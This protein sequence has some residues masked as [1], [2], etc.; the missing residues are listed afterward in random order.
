MNCCRKPQNK[1]CGIGYKMIPA[2]LGDDT[3]EFKPENGAYH[4]M[5]IKYEENGALYFYANDGVYV[6]L[7]ADRFLSEI[8]KWEKEAKADVD[9]QIDERFDELNVQQ[10]VNNKLEEMAA[11]GTLG[12]IIDQYLQTNVAWIFD[13]VADMKA[14]TNLVA[15]SYAQTL[16]FYS[17]NDGGGATYFITDDGTAN[18]MDIIAVGDLYANLVHIPNYYNMKTVGCKANNN[19]FDNSTIINAMMGARRTLFFPYGE[20]YISKPIVI[21]ENHVT[22]RGENQRTR[23]IK[24]TNDGFNLTIETSKGTTYNFNSID[25]NFYIGKATSS[26]GTVSLVKIEDLGIVCYDST[27]TGSSYGMFILGC[28][29][30]KT[31]NVQLIDYNRGIF[32]DDSFALNLNSIEA[33]TFGENRNAVEVKD[34]TAVYI[35]DSYL[36]GRYQSIISDNSRVYCHNVACESH[37]YVFSTVNAGYLTLVNCRSE[38]YASIV[39]A[40]GASQIN[41]T[42]CDLEG[43]GSSFTQFMRVRNNS[44]VSVRNSLIRYRVYEGETA[45]ETITGF[46]LENGSIVTCECYYNIHEGVTVN[47]SLQSSCDLWIIDLNNEGKHATLSPGTGVTLTDKKVYIK[48]GYLNVYLTGNTS[49]AMTQGSST[50]LCTISDVPIPTV[51]HRCLAGTA[52]SNLYTTYRPAYCGIN[53]SG[54]ITLTPSEENQ[55]YFVINTKYRIG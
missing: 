4:N 24:N 3:G 29:Y 19:T 53:T 47:N 41:I 45:P 20:Y 15:G 30:F 5:L 13:T 51:A 40:Q 35:S 43:H 27:N 52:P 55:K 7:D 11:D 37:G 38:T 6:A 2:A 18:E 49:T 50:N 48:D 26:S 12:E 28:G 39:N 36:N 31:N 22:I 14:A 44:K 16:G 34:S 10:E 54:I 32:V 8:S 25:T 46:T 1:C 33:L 9:A 17:I 21:T 23:I 42:S